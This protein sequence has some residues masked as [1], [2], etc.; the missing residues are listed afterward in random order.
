MT[1]PTFFSRLNTDTNLETNGTY[2]L[3][4][5][6]VPDGFPQGQIY[7]QFENVTH[8][9]TGV[10]KVAQL[11]TK[12]LLTQKGSDLL[13]P[14]LGTDFPEYTIGANRIN[15]DEELRT[16]IIKAIRDAGNQAR[17]ILN[18]ANNQD[19]ASQLSQAIF[20]GAEIESESVSVYIK[21]ITM[22]GESA[23]VAVPFPQLDMKLI[24][25]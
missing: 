21:L 17:Y 4:L 23:M 5:I 18:V 22:D 20:Q 2:D 9:I 7:F 3:L 25:E 13:N 16:A 10:Q 12:I 15:E 1:D 6:T 19:T 14:S 11:F 24:G 8:K